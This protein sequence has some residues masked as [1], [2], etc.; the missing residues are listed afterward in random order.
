[1]AGG[2]VWDL[3]VKNPAKLDELSS[4]AISW[5]GKLFFTEECEN[6]QVTVKV[7]DGDTRAL[8]ARRIVDNVGYR[9]VSWDDRWVALAEYVRTRPSWWRD[10]CDR[11]FYDEDLNEN[12][13]VTVIDLKTGQPIRSVPDFGCIGFG[14]NNET[15]WTVN[16]T[17]NANGK[18]QLRQWSVHPPGPPWW[19]WV[20]TAGGVGVI[21]LDTHRVWR[22]FRG[23]RDS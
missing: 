7:Y 12:D 16:Y 19:L 17:K 23:R 5:D 22:S 9:T 10:I 11:W 18:E 1:V 13:V 2:E 14:P 3:T 21:G 15:F 8:I 20:L 4:P 6:E